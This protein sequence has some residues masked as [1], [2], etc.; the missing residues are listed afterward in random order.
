MHTKD[1]IKFALA[2]SNGAV[3][4]V[5]D[6]MSSAATTFPTPNGGCHPLWV[7]GHLTLVEGSIPAILFGEKNPAAEWQQHFGENSEPVADASAYPPFAEVREKYVG[8][9]ERNVKLLES[10]SDANLDKPT[11]APPKGR[12]QEFATYGQTLLVLA[13][14]QTMHRGHV[15]DARRA[16]GRTLATSASN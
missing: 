16:A 11:K 9:R 14:H 5:I 1:A 15:T 10:L 2:V 8:L 12:E 13:M 3:L 4:S 6:E 7:L